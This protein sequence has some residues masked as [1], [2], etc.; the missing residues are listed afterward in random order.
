MSYGR[1]LKMAEALQRQGHQ[2]DVAVPD[3]VAEWYPAR[4]GAAAGQTDPFNA[5][6]L[7]MVPLSQV[8]WRDYDVVKTAFHDGFD[9]LSQYGGADHP[10][11]ISKL[12]S[13]VA[14][15]E[16]DGI[17]FYG[18]HR[19]MLFD[20]QC[21]ISRASRYITVLSEAARALWVECHG[22][23]GDTLLVPGGVDAQLPGPT[24]D[25]YLGDGCKRC[26]F[27]GNI[28]RSDSQ[29][30]ANR[31]LV[32]K[33]NRLGEYLR[34][35]GIRV[36]LL[37]HGNTERLN[38]DWVTH[39]GSVSYEASWDYLYHADVG[40]VV[41]A[42]AFMHNN[43]STKIYHYLRAGLPVVSESGFP[44]DPVV[45]ESGG[46]YLVDGEDMREMADRVE[47]AAAT[48]WDREKMRRYVLDHHTWDTRA[49]V[50]RGV[51]ATLER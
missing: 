46:G 1:W 8:A 19:Q 22:R 38:P 10:F 17:Y 34:P 44:N 30:E 27:S 12:G 41:S 48:D 21:R 16:R 51:I 50:Y 42:G 37:G 9:T 2:V 40:I 3:E 29:P 7:N 43:E 15:E 31:V 33:L 20:I 18:E 25:P 35:A 23:A 11:I 39:L 14:A 28:Y 24:A 6:P 13:V 4:G 45:L 47:L 49:D 32:D 26:V 5:R 36:Y